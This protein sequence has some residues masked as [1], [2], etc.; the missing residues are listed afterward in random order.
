[1]EREDVFMALKMRRSRDQ[2]KTVKPRTK[3]KTAKGDPKPKQRASFRN[4]TKAVSVIEVQNSSDLKGEG[5]TINPIKTEA[6]FTVSVKDLPSTASH[7]SNRQSKLG[8][9]PDQIFQMK[10]K[11]NK[12]YLKE[13]L[14]T[15]NCKMPR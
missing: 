15:S 7:K 6:D 9:Y 14:L 11:K 3:I 12:F 4:K 10:L 8:L 13:N 2:R 1:M 5:Q